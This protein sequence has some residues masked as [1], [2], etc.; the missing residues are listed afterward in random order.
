MK[1]LFVID[2][3]NSGGAE[4]VLINI[5]KRLD[6]KKLEV[7]LLLLFSEGVYLKE[8]PKEIK[9]N[10][11]FWGNGN[12]YFKKKPQLFKIFYKLYRKFLIGLIK[13]CPSLMRA[14]YKLVIHK[15][16][17][18]EIAFVEGITSYVV[19]SSTNIKSKKILWI[20]TDILKRRTMSRSKEKRV[21]SKMNQIICVSEGAKE[22]IL[23]LYP[24]FY[25]KVKVI[26]NPIDSFEII[27][28]SKAII[29]SKKEKITLIS[30]G[31]LDYAKGFDILLKAH[32]ILINEGVDHELIIVGE[33]K[34]R[35]K[36]QKLIVEL[37]VVNTAKL[38]G[39]KENPY[40]YLKNAD[41]FVMSSRYEG[42]PLVLAEALIL[43]K[44]IVATRCTGI[45][46]ILEDGKYGILVEV[47]DIR[48]LKEGIQKMIIN[49]ELRNEYRLKA[50]KRKN[51]FYIDE[52]MKKINGVILN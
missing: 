43:E 28:K 42:F 44:P 27:T 1:L 14:I 30:I 31:R 48:S 49:D 50:I 21:F 36:L 2:S 6:Y 29:A 16:Y 39:Y 26:Y 35:G 23:K 17:D 51:F 34:E 15:K 13:I 25:E 10:K 38:L 9:V 5:L 3:L 18:I 46:E 47:E 37:N 19:L 4:K 20:H 7:E 24:E 52:V 12:E 45:K 32:K 41:I 22:S 11:V 33:G 8:I 40:V